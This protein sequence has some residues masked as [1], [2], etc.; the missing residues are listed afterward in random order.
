MSLSEQPYIKEFISFLQFEKRYAQHTV[1]AYQNDLAQFAAF[2]KSQY[3]I[4]DITLAT[5]PICRTFLAEL[6]ED[7]LSAKS[8]NRKLSA[9]KSFYK[10]LLRINKIKQ[11]P[12]HLIKALNIPKRLPVFVQEADMR[13]MLQK[14]NETQDFEQATK[15]MVI[16]FFYATGIRVS[17]LVQLK[18]TQIDWANSQVKILGKGSKERIVPLVPE[19]LKNLKTYQA[20]L[21]QQN[22]EVR[23]HLFLTKKGKPLYA[24][25]VYKWV[26][27]YLSA[28]ATLSKKSPHVLRHTFATHLMNN[29]ADLNAVKELL[30]HSSLAA[31]QVYTHNN[32][33]QLKNIFKKAHPKAE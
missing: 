33:D 13:A 9:L 3:N 15:Q 10:Y 11:S 2:L 12:L 31:T 17:E 29:G 22:F 18:P 27:N 28:A 5:T 6:K 7:K 1:V 30:G 21:D 32:I 14:E 23:T 8:I 16:E 4:E 19:V 20:L 26:N 24:R 25:L